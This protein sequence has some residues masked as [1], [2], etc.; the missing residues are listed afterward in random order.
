MGEIL[1]RGNRLRKRRAALVL[2]GYV[3]G[4]WVGELI[5]A[6]FDGR[7]QTHRVASDAPAEGLSDYR[8]GLI[9][10]RATVTRRVIP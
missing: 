7:E 2:S 6:G 9:V 5:Y 3:A 8:P 4:A 10:A 1:M